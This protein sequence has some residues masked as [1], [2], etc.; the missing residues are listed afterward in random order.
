MQVLKVDNHIWADDVAYMFLRNNYPNVMKLRGSLR[1]QPSSCAYCCQ[2][3]SRSA[4][5]AAGLEEVAEGLRW[6]VVA[7][8]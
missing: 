3:S 5:K 1:P 6:K 2:C 4:D 7:Q 8:Q